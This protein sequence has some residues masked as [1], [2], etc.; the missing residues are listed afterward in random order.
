MKLYSA[1]VRLAGNRDNEVAKDNLTAAEIH[2]LNHIHGGE[3]NHAAVINIVHTAN[4]NRTDTR[5]R[6]RLA[7]IYTKGELVEDRGEK[8]L[9]SLFGVPGSMPLPQEYIEPVIEAVDLD[10][11]APQEAEEITPVDQPAAPPVVRTIVDKTDDL[12]NLVA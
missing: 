3:G 9:T 11:D 4:V 2:V 6:A 10:P 1:T 5:E 8:I 12:E 7:S